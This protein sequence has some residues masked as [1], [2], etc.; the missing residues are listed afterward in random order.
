MLKITSLLT[1]LSDNM[2]SQASSYIG[3]SQLCTVNHRTKHT[4]LKCHRI[5][6]SQ[7]KVAGEDICCCCRLIVGDFLLVYRD[8][9]NR[10]NVLICPQPATTEKERK[11][12]TQPRRALN[13]LNNIQH[14]LIKEVLRL[15]NL[16]HDYDLLEKHR[17]IIRV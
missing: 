1:V 12:W 9:S 14:L 17:W 7:W 6:G 4:L 16:C 13:T 8:T 3:N 2:V 11:T 15:I 5:T 10:A